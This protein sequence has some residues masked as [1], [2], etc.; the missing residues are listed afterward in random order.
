MSLFSMQIKILLKF[1][2]NNRLSKTCENPCS[3]A[4][5]QNEYKALHERNILEIFNKVVFL[6]ITVD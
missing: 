1:F 6:L 4:K 5:K 3:L 2:L